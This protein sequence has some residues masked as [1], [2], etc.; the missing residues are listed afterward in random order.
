MTKQNFL[1]ALQKALVG[2]PQSDVEERIGFYAEMIDDRMEEGLTEEA[3]VDDVGSV[4]DVAA[5]IITDTPLISLVKTSIAPK[6]RL[7]VWEIVLLVLGSPIWL[8]LLIAAAA[9]LL[10]LYVS[11]WSLMIALWSVLV[12]L[13]AMSVG[14]WIGGLVLL[15]QNHVP[16]GLVCIAVSFVSAGLCIPVYYGCKAATKGILVLTKRVALAIKKA[17]MRK[18]VAE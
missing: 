1:A 11:L 8:S 17:C 16:S 4:D 6:R 12:A 3:A 7:S 5:Q 9:I 13:A 10:S 14:T 15:F 2:L 18:E